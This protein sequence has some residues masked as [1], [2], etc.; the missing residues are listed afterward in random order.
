MKNMNE[1][2]IA[3][4]GTGYVGLS[5]ATLLSQQAQQQADRTIQQAEAGRQETLAKANVDTRI[6]L[7]L[8]QTRRDGSD[9]GLLLRLWRDAVSRI[10]SQAG[11]VITVAP[12]DDS[13]LILQGLPPQPATPPASEKSP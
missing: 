7:Q 3:V 4:A 1:L 2:V 6:I 5:I 9:G 13:R 8:A 10:L 12:G 11:Q